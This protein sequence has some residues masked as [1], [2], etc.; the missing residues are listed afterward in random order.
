MECPVC[1]ESTTNI[2][3][4]YNH[5]ICD[6][7]IKQYVQT[8][9]SLCRSELLPEF[10]AI[11]Q[12]NKMRDEQIN[13]VKSVAEVIFQ[14]L[15]SFI[16]AF[17]ITKDSLPENITLDLGLGPI[18]CSDLLKKSIDQITEFATDPEY[19]LSKNP[20]CELIINRGSLQYKKL[21]FQITV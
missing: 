13:L 5:A 16:Q 21:L 18:N 6:D 17:S 2:V 20:W 1:N 14:G 19:S 7:C 15:H 12:K 10:R 9:C 4:Q 8:T 3:C 11:A